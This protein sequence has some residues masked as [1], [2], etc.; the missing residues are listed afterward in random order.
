MKKWIRRIRTALQNRR[1]TTLIEAA[2]GL[3]ILTFVVVSIYSG[4]VVAQKIFGDG[5]T[6]EE[7][8]QDSY[9]KIESG[10]AD[11]E[12]T[13]AVFLPLGD[14]KVSFRGQYVKSGDASK[15]AVLYSFETGSTSNFADNVRNTFIYWKL[16]IDAATPEER[17][18]LNYTSKWTDNSTMRKWLWTEIYGGNWPILPTEFLERYLTD[19]EKKNEQNGLLAGPVYVQ[20]YNTPTVNDVEQNC[21][22]FAS[23]TQKD[24]WYIRMIYDHEEHAW[25]YR[26]AGYS[27]EMVG[28]EWA[29]VKAMIHTSDWRKLV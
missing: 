15:K 25:Y 28:K 22:V 18:E 19:V 27:S 21:F 4:F 14:Q 8:G 7:Q 10:S 23:T 12:G 29:Y 26:T 5:D 1:G 17:K 3:L 11:A 13:E 6:R 20:P 16:R 24:H 2:T 9:G